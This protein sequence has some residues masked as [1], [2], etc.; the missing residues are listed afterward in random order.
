MSLSGTGTSLGTS[1][2]GEA[3]TEQKQ[4]AA[5]KMTKPILFQTG[6]NCISFISFIVA[7]Y[8]STDIFLNIIEELEKMIDV[9]SK[10]YSSYLLS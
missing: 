4:K 6:L 2:K 9:T 7:L 1:S 8:T 3:Q 10:R 5:M